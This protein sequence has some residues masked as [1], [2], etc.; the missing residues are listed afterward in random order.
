MQGTIHKKKI[1]ILHSKWRLLAYS[2]DVAWILN[3]EELKIRYKTTLYNLVSWQSFPQILEAS[4][5]I[6][7]CNSC[8]DIPL[9]SCFLCHACTHVLSQLHKPWHSMKMWQY[10]ALPTYAVTIL[11][12]YSSILWMLFYVIQHYWK[13][14]KHISIVKT[15]LQ[16]GQLPKWH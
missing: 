2:I 7:L 11:Y 1:L 12:N 6:M 3:V 9:N 13:F 5:T 10:V 16:N 8:N 14:G 15:S 4:K